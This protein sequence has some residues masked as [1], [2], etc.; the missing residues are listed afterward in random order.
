MLADTPA[1]ACTAS[2][3]DL[4]LTPSSLQI[5]KSIFSHLPDELTAIRRPHNEAIR[6]VVISSLTRSL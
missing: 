5:L 6:V 2:Q 3:S 4:F 1:A